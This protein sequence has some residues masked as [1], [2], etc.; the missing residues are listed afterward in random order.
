VIQP[1]GV[2]GDDRLPARAPIDGDPRSAGRRDPALGAALR[3]GDRPGQRS[4]CAERLPRRAS[5]SAT[6]ETP[7]TERDGMSWEE[8]VEELRRRRELARRMGGPENV[9]RQ[10]KAGR[11]TVRERIEQLLD[12]HSFSETGSLAG[13]ATYQDGKL[14]SFLPANS[15]LGLGRIG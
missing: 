3:R 5:A 9:E 14:E 13:K 15:V 10:R 12:G 8:E 1:S 4:R 2:W 11:L 7:P 6:A